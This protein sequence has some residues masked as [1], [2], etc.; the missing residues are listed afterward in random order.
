MTDQILLKR[1][2]LARVLGVAEI[3][4]KRW[5]EQGLPCIRINTKSLYYDI[6]EVRAWMKTFTE[7]K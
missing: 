7:G 2:D 4:I 1:K 6:N 5:Q 3:T